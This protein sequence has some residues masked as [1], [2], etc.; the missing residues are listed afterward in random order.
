MGHIGFIGHFG[1]MDIGQLKPGRTP[2]VSA[3]QITKWA[4]PS[5]PGS[6]F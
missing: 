4:Y 5:H 1:L 6:Q 3:A 2:V